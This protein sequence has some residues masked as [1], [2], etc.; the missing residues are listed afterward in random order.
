[1][2]T[3][4]CVFHR[5]I[6]YNSCAF[7]QMSANDSST[8]YLL[9]DNYLGNVDHAINSEKPMMLPQKKRPFLSHF[10]WKMIEA[11]GEKSGIGRG[12][13]V[14]R[15]NNC[16]TICIYWNVIFQAATTICSN[17]KIIYLP[18]IVSLRSHCEHEPCRKFSATY[19]NIWHSVFECHSKSYNKF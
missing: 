4:N 6:L 18:K 15:P 9:N 16:Q 8:L 14:K 2:F 17:N 3:E 13:L 5:P 7:T 11:T 10:K 19:E 1:M 12:C